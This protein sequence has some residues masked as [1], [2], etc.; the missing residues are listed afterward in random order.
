MIDITEYEVD[1]LDCPYCHKS[2]LGVWV[3][4]DGDTYFALCLAES[5][6]REIL[7]IENKMTSV[8]SNNQRWLV[9]GKVGDH[10]TN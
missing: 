7:L 4:Q 6:E 3:L 8:T 10:G 9:A 2:H 1:I 5:T